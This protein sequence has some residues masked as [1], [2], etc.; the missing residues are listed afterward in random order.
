MKIFSAALASLV[1]ITPPFPSGEQFL[2]AKPQKNEPLACGSTGVLNP[3]TDEN[4]KFITVLPGWGKHS[5]SIT[6]T[7]DSA[8]F[9][10]NQGLSLYYSYHPKQSVASFREAARFSK[11]CAMAYWGQA[12]AMGPFYNDPGYKMSE[13]LPAVIQMMNRY[14]EN[15]T[16]REKGL[17]DAMQLRYSN[18]LSNAD[19]PQL[20]KK[21]AAAMAGL[22]KAYPDDNDIKGLY[23]D[24]VMLQHKWDFWNNDGSARPWTPE[25]VKLCEEILKKDRLHPAAMHYYIHVTEASKQPGL[26]LESAEL[27]KDAMPGTA[28]M[29]HMASHMYQRNGLFTKGVYVNE[30]ANGAS[31]FVDSLFPAVGNGQN[32]TIHYF[33]V[34][35]YCAMSAGMYE[36]AMNVYTRARK[37][38]VDLNGALDNL[39]YAQFVYMLPV[40]AAVRMGKWEEIRRMPAVDPNWKYAAIMDDFARG[41]AHIRNGD[42]KAAEACLG[43][44][45][46]NITDTTLQL[47]RHPFNKPVQSCRIALEIL[48]A[49]I[50]AAKNMN[51]ESI[52][53]FRKAIAE[54][55]Q[56]IYSEPQ[57]WLIPSRQFLG[58]FLLKL[59]RPEAAGEVFKEDLVSH[60]GN[61][62]SLMGMYQSLV[63]RNRHQEAKKYKQASDDA[64]HEA[65]VMPKSS[66]F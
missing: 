66:V 6:T 56:L 11:T 19:R 10:F 30:S 63:A 59:K 29:V 45:E 14:K 34:Q 47:R 32:T 3:V 20:D 27:L 12:L 51:S 17:I 40:M 35:S 52:K 21:Y 53:A 18:D 38:V 54:E 48:R 41:L 22:I 5:Y 26:A 28:H 55:D 13:Q 49:E 36:K 7:S 15:C 24:A 2:V 39:P 50:F 23:I 65:D 61:G 33:A 4:G 62:W 16:D 42:V 25:L 64:F 31:N 44:I 43:Q 1:V 57:E 37:R 58:N 9:Y 8:Q 46:L 60:P